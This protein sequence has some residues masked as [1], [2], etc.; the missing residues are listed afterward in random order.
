MPT[1]EQTYIKNYF[2]GAWCKQLSYPLEEDVV[3]EVLHQVEG[4]AAEI[5]SW[6]E[7]AA[8]TALLRQLYA[9]KLIHY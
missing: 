3:S 8:G 6:E 4:D 1:H 2:I 7:E 5:Q 9:T